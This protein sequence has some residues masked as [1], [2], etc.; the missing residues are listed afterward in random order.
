MVLCKKLIISFRISLKHFS[1]QRDLIKSMC[2]QENVSGNLGLDENMLMEHSKNQQD[3]EGEVK[4]KVT[5]SCPILCNLM[6][7]TVHGI[8]QARILEW[9]AFSFSRGSSQPRY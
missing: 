5:Q 9:V 8:L 3:P 4:V 6:D 7:Y 1:V 2:L